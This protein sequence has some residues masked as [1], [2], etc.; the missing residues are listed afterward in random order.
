MQS[1]HQ[2]PGGQ[3]AGGRCGPRAKRKQLSPKNPSLK[4]RWEIKAFPEHQK[5]R[6]CDHWTRPASNAPGHPAGDGKGHRQWP[7]VTWRSKIP[8]MRNTWTVMKASTMVTMILALH[9]LAYMWFKRLIHL[10]KKA[11]IM[12]LKASITVTLVQQT[13]TVSSNPCTNNSTA[14]LGKCEIL[15]QTYT[16]QHNTASQHLLSRQNT[17]LLPSIG[18]GLCCANTPYTRELEDASVHVIL[19]LIHIYIYSYEDDTSLEF[20]FKN[21]L[22]LHWAKVQVS[23]V[24]CRDWLWLPQRNN[25]SL[26]LSSHV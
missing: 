22:L 13:K 4:S 23:G 3:K 15:A 12:T 7:E 18:T 14:L 24:C 10:R 1:S 16:N 11:K 25:H 26:L 17:H 2:T 20:L 9:L 19:K 8:A 21:T 6:S 5:L